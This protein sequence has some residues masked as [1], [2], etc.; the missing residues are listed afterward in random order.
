VSNQNR[1]KLIDKSSNSVW[2]LLWSS[3]GTTLFLKTDFFDPFNSA[4]LIFLLITSAWLV[5]HLI[6]SY[7]ENPIS[8]KSKDSIPTLLVLSFIIFLFV[9]TLMTDIVIVA[10]L[11]ETQRRNGFLAYLGLSII[12]LFASRKIN[13][14]YSLRVYKVAIITGII[15]GTY[16]LIQIFGKDFIKWN[17][18][19]NS[20]IGTLGNPNFASAT[21]A[22]LFLLSFYGLFLRNIPKIYK[23]L[24]IIFLL[25]GIIAIIVSGSRQGLLT[26]FFSVIFY[27]SAFTYLKYKKIGKLVLVLSLVSAMMATLGML[28]KGPFASLLY[29]DSVSVRGYYWR[30]GIE[31]FKHSPLAG[32]GVDRYGTYFKEFREVGYPLK[33][34]FD[35]TSTNAHNTF[36][37]LFATAGF[38]VGTA[39]LLLAGY[40][41]YTGINLVRKSNEQ[42]RL[43][44]LGLLSSWVGFQAQSLISIDNLGISVWGWLLGG[45]LIGL[46]R[47][48]QTGIR[49]SLNINYN[50]KTSNR[51]QINLFQPVISALI[52][53]PTIF[54]SSVINNFEKN[55]YFA[56]V[57]AVPSIPQN[58]EKV[59]DYSKMVLSSIFVDP[60]YKYRAAVL[61]SN[62]GDQEKAFE[63]MS[64]LQKEDPRNLDYIRGLVY[65]EE[66]RENILGVIVLRE[67]ISKADPWNAENYFQLLKLYKK[68]G[69]LLKAGEMKDKIISFAPKSEL[70]KSASEMLG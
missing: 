8:L 39:Y 56:G 28:Q 23:L 3:A 1:S 42:E 34:G 13:I 45:S 65:F 60:S 20:M 26:I 32:I 50:S 43:I 46:S 31:M 17:N 4:K 24:A 41:F 36:I 58:K 64:N 22:I 52:L 35:I 38:F 68:T 53:V 21:L 30:A 63:I 19:Y 10:L 9:S 49:E 37:Q 69:D 12:F 2:F 7:R 15:V 44:S 25:V 48:N 70:A 40:V 27:L 51:V 54:F 5:G 59:D 6:N 33:Y 66:L 14:L 18:P 55:L 62:M 67:K 57:L 11:G 47:N 29:K 61:L 16:G